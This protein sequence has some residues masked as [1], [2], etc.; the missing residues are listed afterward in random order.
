MLRPSLG[1]K[2]SENG[3]KKQ[4]ANIT[5]PYIK[6]KEKE[7]DKTGNGGASRDAKSPTQESLSP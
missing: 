2:K 3:Q 4:R 6:I 5:T 7:L 1:R